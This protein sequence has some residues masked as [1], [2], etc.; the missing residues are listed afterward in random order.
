MVAERAIVRAARRWHLPTLAPMQDVDAKK[1]LSFALMWAM[2]QR[3]VT[4]PKLAQ[5]IGKS[6]D[7]VRRW[8][9][10]ESAP[11][12]L[13]VASLARALGVRVDYF[14]NPPEVPD[15]PFDDFMIPG[16]GFPTLREARTD[17]L[18]EGERRG[19]ARAQRAPRKPPQSPE[20]PAPG[21]GE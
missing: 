3:D 6:P 13:D 12:V 10:G 11:S 1:K 19:A 5:A 2:W 21:N 20:R 14:T 17:A 16:E 8:R 18:Q 7:A 9:D 4:P 15:Y